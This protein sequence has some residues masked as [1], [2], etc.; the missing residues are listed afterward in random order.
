VKTTAGL[1]SE[2]QQEKSKVEAL[3]TDLASAKSNGAD[4][5]VTLEK[6]KEVSLYRAYGHCIG[7][8][9]ATL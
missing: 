8:S 4:L 9:I 2:L 5:G 3:S 7:D 1:R 6:E